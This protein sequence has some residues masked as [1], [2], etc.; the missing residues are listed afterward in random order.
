MSRR[1]EPD[2]LHRWEGNPILTVEDIPFRCNAVFNGSPIKINGEYL[3]LLRVEGQQGYSFLALARGEDGYHFEVDPK[4][5]MMPEKQDIFAKYETRGLED[6]R[7]TFLDGQY[8][9]LYTAASDYGG[10]IVIAKTNDF[11]NYERIA[12]ISEPGN[13][14]CVLFPEKIN[15]KFA[16]LDRPLG[17]NDLGSIWI[18]YS[19]DLI[20]W[21]YHEPVIEPRPGYWD[22]HRI[23]ASVPPI[24]TDKGWLEIYHGFKMTAC[25]PIYRMGTV[26]MDLQNPAKVIA[27]RDEAILS[28]REKYER[29]GD[30]NNVVFACGGIVE[31]DKQLKIYYGGADTSLCIATVD[32]DKL[33]GETCS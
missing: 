19:E 30:V 6:P 20:H 16:R 15:G 18:S 4:P 13:K 22:A 23:G 26:L 11:K 27:R 7:I 24:K 28:P 21:G 12:F 3:I 1:R 8:Y 10:R 5:V 33:I 17:S 32:L 9:I 29:V 25:G 14:D 2:L 31:P